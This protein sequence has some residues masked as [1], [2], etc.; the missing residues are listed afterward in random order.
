[1]SISTKPPMQLQDE[2]FFRHRWWWDPVPDW[3]LR[4]IPDTAI[5]ELA[6]VQLEAQRAMLDVQKVA[7]DRAM[8]IMK[9][10]R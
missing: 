8:E 3:V 4:H 2:L 1:M 6:V 7:L 10:A 5:R 9:K